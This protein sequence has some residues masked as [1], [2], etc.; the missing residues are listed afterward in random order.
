L[1]DFTDCDAAGGGEVELLIVLN[2]PAALRQQRVD[3]LAR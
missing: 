2:E 3:I 1:T